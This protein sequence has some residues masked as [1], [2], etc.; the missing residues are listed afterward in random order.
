[1]ANETG[2]NCRTPDLPVET[3]VKKVTSRFI[4][5]DVTMHVS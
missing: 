1:M 5:S 3:G 2:V 4:K